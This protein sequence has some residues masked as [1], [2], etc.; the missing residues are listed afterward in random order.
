MKVE[1][2]SELIKMLNSRLSNERRQAAEELSRRKTTTSINA[3]IAITNRTWRGLFRR[4][5]LDA[6]LLGIEWL[7]ESGTKEALEFLEHLYEDKVTVER[8]EETWYYGVDPVYGAWSI[9][10]HS[11]P[12]AKGPLA[13]ALRYEIRLS[14]SGWGEEFRAKSDVESERE[15]ILKQKVA[16]VVIRNAIT[17]LKITSTAQ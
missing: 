2:E 16:H 9:E 10:F 15:E 13:K 4:C 8:H 12:N 6:Q 7:G 1:K 17:K 5:S 11:Y 3:L 14:H